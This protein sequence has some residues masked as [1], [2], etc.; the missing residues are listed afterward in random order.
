MR[1]YLLREKKQNELMSKRHK[2][3]CRVLHYIDH[4]FIVISRTAGCV[5]TSIFASLVDVSIGI[6][7]VLQ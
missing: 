3:A 1:N 6:L 7:Q 2:K 4:L 5:S